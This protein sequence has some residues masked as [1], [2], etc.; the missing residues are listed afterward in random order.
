MGRSSRRASTRARTR[1]VG[2]LDPDKKCAEVDALNGLAGKDGTAQEREAKI[3]L[4]SGLTLNVSNENIRVA[5]PGKLTRYD[6][7]AGKILQETALPEFGG[8][9]NNSAGGGLFSTD[10][11]PLDPQ[12][13]EA[14]A[15]NLKTPARIALPA[16]LANAQHEQQLEAAL[17]DD[18]Q[19]PRPKNF[20]SPPADAES[21]QLVPGE[22]GFV[23][24]FTRLL[25]KHM[26]TRS[27]MKAPRE[28]RAQRRSERHE[29]DRS[30]QRNPE[31]NAA[32]QRRRHGHG[33]RKPLSSHRAFARFCRHA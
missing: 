3:A 12:K 4:Q 26:V 22:N 19:H 21:F 5:S 18:P 10:G 15:Q 33:R 11:Q 14:Q 24:F 1:R 20:Q 31:R 7:D 6:W 29:D 9:E 2:P 17:N 23:Q 25:E 13:V 28:I 30:G 32:Q 27:A 16:L 8:A